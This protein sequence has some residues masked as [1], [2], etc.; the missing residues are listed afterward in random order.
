MI[1]IIFFIISLTIS[2]WLNAQNISKIQTIR[3]V[4]DKNEY[5]PTETIY[6]KCYLL[7]EFQQPDSTEKQVYI[8][9]L[10]PDNTV[11]YQQ[12]IKLKNGIAEGQLQLPDSCSGGWYFIRAIAGNYQPDIQTTYALKPV[13]I[14]NPE[15]EFYTQEYYADFYKHARLVRKS[16]KHNKS[17]EKF[18]PNEPARLSPFLISK[19][20]TGDSVELLFLENEV[21]NNFDELSIAVTQHPENESE[22][23]YDTKKVKQNIFAQFT[24][25]DSTLTVSGRISKLFF[26]LPAQ[27]IQV[28]L[29]V[30]NE[31]YKKLT[32]R[33]DS[34]GRFVFTGLDYPDTM[35]LRI[36]S[37]NAYG[38][39]SYIVN[40]DDAEYPPSPQL[41]PANIKAEKERLKRGK[42]HN[43]Q[44][45][46][47]EPMQDT[48]SSSKLHRTVNQVLYFDKLNVS[49]YTDAL[50]AISAFVPGVSR[51]GQSALRGKTSFK[52][53]SEPLYLLDDIP[54]DKSTISSLPPEQVE[55]VEIVKGSNA[56]IYGSRSANGVIA[57][58]TKHG[59]NIQIGHYTFLQIGYLTPIVFEYKPEFQNAT[60]FWSSNFSLNEKGKTTITIPKS[61]ADTYIVKISGFINSVYFES[62]VVL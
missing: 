40:V 17:V 18:S 14:N 39:K 22:F 59:Y 33:T 55:R 57:V 38:K 50:S 48:S 46:Q 27:N 34:S 7:N 36:E 30:L 3:I 62:E 2:F 56:A 43:R 45:Y 41:F 52:L 58:Y 44:T 51:F 60:L 12:I 15:K 29:F 47:Y 4:T 42:K 1:R 35:E 11:G 49:G 37:Y 26:D 23:I 53:S 6:L 32:T 21:H 19:R 8:Q 31:H 10:F 16:G 61:Q 54:V 28:T 24:T 9:Y 25:N 20:E 13:F 5:C